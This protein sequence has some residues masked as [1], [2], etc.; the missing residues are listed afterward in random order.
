[1]TVCRLMMIMTMMMMM[2][3]TS[4][5]IDTS[6]F[7]HDD[8]VINCHFLVHPEKGMKET[9]KTVRPEGRVWKKGPKTRI[10]P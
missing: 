2:M 4:M 7:I 5:V 6:V 9:R 10:K 1:M 8:Y 3:M